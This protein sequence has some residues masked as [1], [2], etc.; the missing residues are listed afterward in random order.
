MES[1]GIKIHSIYYSCC[2]LQQL[3]NPCSDFILV[4]SW[5]GK[6]LRITMKVHKDGEEKK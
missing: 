6:N 1:E 2:V 3:D 5:C 4:C